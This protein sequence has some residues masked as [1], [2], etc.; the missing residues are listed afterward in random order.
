[1]GTNPQRAGLYKYKGAAV[2]IFCMGEYNYYACRIASKL[3]TLFMSNVYKIKN[4]TGRRI[5]TSICWWTYKAFK[6]PLR[7]LNLFVEKG[8]CRYFPGQGFC[9]SIMMKEEIFPTMRVQFEDTTM[10][11]PH[12]YDAYL[13]R[14]YSTHYM[15]IPKDIELHNKDLVK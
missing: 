13:S 7:I 6:Q 1:L 4:K 2:D 10:P 9:N 5:V 12:N 15:T 3:H 14:L 8:K 11:I